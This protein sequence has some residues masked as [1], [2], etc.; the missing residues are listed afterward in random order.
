MGSEGQRRLGCSSNRGDYYPPGWSH[1]KES[2]AIQEEQ[3]AG[4]G[5]DAL[6]FILSIS[7]ATNR[8]AQTRIGLGPSDGTEAIRKQFQR[9]LAV[10]A[11]PGGSQQ[12]GPDSADLGVRAAVEDAAVIDA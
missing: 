3:L 10:M 4:P 2:I 9:F 8:P 12:P 5:H 7:Q 11:G 6:G 1:L